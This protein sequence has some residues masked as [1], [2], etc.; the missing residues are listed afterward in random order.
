MRIPYPIGAAL[1]LFTLL[2]VSSSAFGQQPL[3]K[4]E[5]GAQF[6]LLSLQQPN[7]VVGNG[8]DPGGQRVVPGVGTNTEP[9][10]GGRF[11]FNLTNYLAVEAEGNLFPKSEPSV[12]TP[13]GRIFQGQFGIK[14]GK[15]FQR[16]GI[17]AKARP[18]LVGFTQVSKLLS[19]TS[20]N[21]APGLPPF[22]VGTFGVDRD[23]YF[24]LDAGAVV[25]YYA[26]Q[27]VLP[28][29]DLGD[30]IVRYGLYQTQGNSLSRAIITRPPET[31]HNLQFSAGVGFRF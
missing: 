29:F 30:T 4:F 16:F 12:G 22:T 7:H 23:V 13:G 8:I 17:F 19:T 2:F 28:R 11:T 26:S 24:S 20:V 1:S 9:G 3:P 25:E 6:S 18:G 5:I 10:F 27:R 15:R 21:N 31:R 14:A